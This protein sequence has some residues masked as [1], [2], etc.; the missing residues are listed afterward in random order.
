MKTNLTDYGFTPAFMQEN[1]AGTIARVTAV[2]RERYEL[3]CEFGHISAILKSGVYFNQQSEAFPTAGDFVLIDYNQSGDSRI[4][5]TLPRKTFFSR[6]DPTP[7]RGEQA[8]AANFDYVFIMQSLNR[9]FNLKRLERYLAIAWQSGALPAVILTKADLAEDYSEQLKAVQKIAKSA[10]VYAVS[11]LTRQGLEQLDDYLKP[12]KTLVFLGSSGVGKSSLVNVLAG[13]DLM[14][15]K[16][17]REDDSRG[18]HT[19]THRELIM[20]PSGVMIIDTPGMRELGL[21]DAGESVDEMFGD[22]EQY[23]GQC[24]FSDCRHESEPNCAIKYAIES[25]ELSLRRWESYLSLKRDASYSED[26]KEYLRQKSAEYQKMEMWWRK[27]K[28]EKR[29]NT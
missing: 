8:I 16:A 5:K 20:L 25:G 19:T 15:V 11:A 13:E 29:R 3:I 24:G 14:A 26:K 21:W 7:G 23:F 27:N 28:S 4:T 12:R 17:I 18:R 2:H 1:E 6:R 9:D 22:V 10:G